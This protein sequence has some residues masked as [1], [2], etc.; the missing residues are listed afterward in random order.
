MFFC[1]TGVLHNLLGYVDMEELE[2]SPNAPLSWKG[3]AM[4][5]TIQRIRA[6]ASECFHWTVNTGQGIDLMVVRNGYRWGFEFK[7]D[8]RPRITRSMKMAMHELKLDRLD[9]IHSSI[10]P[11]ILD[12][13]IPVHTV[14]SLYKSL[15]L[16]EGFERRA[17]FLALEED[18]AT[19]NN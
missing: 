10:G 17:E 14:Q 13:K 2:E 16:P 5:S 19:E 12:G 1:D 11:G 6:G 9:M 3:F 8:E 7:F 4:E 18:L 15:R